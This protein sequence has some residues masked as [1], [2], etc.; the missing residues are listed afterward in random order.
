MDDHGSID[1]GDGL[2][3]VLASYCLNF[4]HPGHLL[5]EPIAEE[6]RMKQEETKETKHESDRVPLKPFDPHAYEAEGR[7]TDWTPPQSE[8]FDPYTHFGDE[9]RLGSRWSMSTSH[10]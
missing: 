2:M 5:A 3:I 8:T 7:V 1:L 10:P 9:T 4:L 6:R